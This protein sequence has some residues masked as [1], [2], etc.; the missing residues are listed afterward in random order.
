MWSWETGI[1]VF[2]TENI[3]ETLHMMGQIMTSPFYDFDLPRQIFTG[4]DHLHRL[5]PVLTGWIYVHDTALFS[6][7]HTFT[8]GRK[9]SIQAPRR[10]QKL[11]HPTGT[12]KKRVHVHVTYPMGKLNLKKTDCTSLLGL[13]FTKKKKE[14]KNVSC[15]YDRLNG[16]NS[17][18]QAAWHHETRSLGV[19]VLGS[20][21]YI[22]G[23]HML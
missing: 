8:G 12:S 16:W 17:T 5:D 18:M 3:L 13:Y 9:T 19:L 21:L 11:Q 1:P 15:A 14:K 22:T 7:T 10:P 6:R 2:E 23:G 20:Y 4:I